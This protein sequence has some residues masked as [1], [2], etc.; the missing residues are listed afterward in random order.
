M[1]FHSHLETLRR[2]R[3]STEHQQ[4]LLLLEVN[5]RIAALESAIAEIQ[6]AKKNIRNQPIHA[7]E[8]FI[9]GSELHFDESCIS[10]LSARHSELRHQLSAEHRDREIRQEAFYQARREREVVETLITHHREA[11]TREESRRQQRRIDDLFLLQ[12]RFRK[13]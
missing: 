12:I 11:Y 5:Q 3:R 8:D 10:A 6:T 7:T 2:L 13:R 1:P 4:E 9:A